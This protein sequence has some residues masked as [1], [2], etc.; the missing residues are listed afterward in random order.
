MT[1]NLLTRV[2]RYLRP[3]HRFLGPGFIGFTMTLCAVMTI[4]DRG[5]FWL[6]K[7]EECYLELWMSHLRYDDQEVINY[8]KQYVIDPPQEHPPNPP[9]SIEVNNPAWEAIGDWDHIQNALRSI[10]VLRKNG[11]FVEVGAG[12][13]VFLSHTIWLEVE[14]G[15]KGLLIEPRNEAYK[16][17]RQRRRAASALACVSDEMHSKKDV[18]WSPFTTND[19]SSANF[20]SKIA[21]GKSTLLRYVAPED[22]SFGKTRSVQCFSLKALILAGVEMKKTID[23]LVIQTMGGEANILNAIPDVTVLVLLIRHH[24]KIDLDEIKEAA[25]TMNMKS[26]DGLKVSPNQYLLFI[27]KTIRFIEGNPNI[28][29][30]I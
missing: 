29:R 16:E 4:R 20:Y 19:G 14:M 7:C 17:L 11:I 2:S 25:A 5:L 12:D 13:G 22:Q 1:P 23:F 10:F 24:T 9:K 28:T 30:R 6:P 26:F 3:M 27:H 21:S 8:L 15:W 18:L